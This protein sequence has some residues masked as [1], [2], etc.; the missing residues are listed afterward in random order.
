MV[1]TDERT[2]SG[3]RQRVPARRLARSVWG[4]VGQLVTTVAR[5]VR[6]GRWR[7]F[8]L[9]PAAALAIA[10]LALADRTRGGYRLIQLTAI[11]R[12]DQ[13]W[14]LWL[15]R[16]PLSAVAP[17]QLLPF[18][19]AMLEVLLVFGSAQV[20]LGLR[21]TVGLGFVG[22]ALATAS[23]LVWV[24]LG[25]PVGVA[26]SYRGVPDAGPSAAVVTLLVYL[27]LRYRMVLVVAAYAA[28]QAVETVTLNGL[29]QREHFVAAVVG[30]LAA[31]AGRWLP[32]WA[33]PPL[34]R[35]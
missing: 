13:P 14:Y 20:V 17:A 2:G 18:W 6:L 3:R 29:T 33:H 30:I 24:R 26:A 22:H 1:G 8:W 9:G 7:R 32:A 19:F 5:A 27:A 25:P 35:G 31:V 34:A 16:L 10:A 4:D 15:A 23:A 11:V 21:Y 12:A 28:F